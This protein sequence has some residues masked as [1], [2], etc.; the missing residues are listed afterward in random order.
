MKVQFITDRNEDDETLIYLNDI[1]NFHSVSFSFSTFNKINLLRDFEE[2]IIILDQIVDGVASVINLKKVYESL[3]FKKIYLL[4]SKNFT[5][6]EEMIINKYK[7]S[8]F[9]IPINEYEIFNRI[10]N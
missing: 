3:S 9:T 5:E 4:T 6:T 2:N 1:F 10:I 8:V 7:I